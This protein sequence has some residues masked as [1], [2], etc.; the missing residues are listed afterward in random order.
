MTILR[1]QVIQFCE[2]HV[3]TLIASKSNAERFSKKLMMPIQ[4][5]DVTMTFADIKESKKDF[6]YNPKTSLEQGIKK[7]VNWYLDYSS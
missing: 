7:F 4:P 5:G 2:S 6:D 3:R 1:I